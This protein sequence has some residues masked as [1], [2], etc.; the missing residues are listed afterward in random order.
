M[1]NDP[2]LPLV[3]GR[4]GEAGRGSL[5]TLV[6]VMIV[7]L[8]AISMAAPATAGTAA[9]VLQ[10]YRK[11]YGSKPSGASGVSGLQAPASTLLR[12]ALM[13]T[14]APDLYDARWTVSQLGLEEIVLA[15]LARGSASAPPAP[16]ELEAA[17]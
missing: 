12:A 16:V 2:S 8:A 9:L 7:C 10:A 17:S 11:A 3:R 13:N 6:A 5:T 4:A 14:A 15:Y 1:R